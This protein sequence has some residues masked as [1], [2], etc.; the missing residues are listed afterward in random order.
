MKEKIKLYQGYFIVFLLSIICIF[1][2]PMIGGSSLN[3]VFALPN[4]A[5]G[6]I[7]WV[8]SKLAV[9]LINMLTFDQFVRQAKINVRDN[10][11][12]IEAQTIFN[13]LQTS[14]EEYLPTP[15]EYLSKLYRN[16]GTK[17]FLT[18]GLSLVAFSNAILSFD[19][20]TMLTYLFTIVT[21]IIF[22]WITMISVEDYWTDTYYKLAK[23]EQQKQNENAERGI[24]AT[25][26][27]AAYVENI[28]TLLE[29]KE[30][31][32]KTQ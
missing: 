1:F 18:S 11:K 8:V 15:N 22:G 7:L 30:N 17:V 24:K 27:P 5:A 19:W 26:T 31:V 28:N 10:E 20:V 21:N 2:L 3:I 9:I 25:L 4:T 29:E 13:T 16:K 6:W 14:E 12:F 32:N 23:R